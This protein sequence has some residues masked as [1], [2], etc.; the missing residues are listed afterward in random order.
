MAGEL[1]T[2][3]RASPRWHRTLRRASSPPIFWTARTCSCTGSRACSPAHTH[4]HM[5]TRW[6]TLCTGSVFISCTYRNLF[7]AVFTTAG[8]TGTSD[9]HT[10]TQ[11]ALSLSFTGC[12]KEKKPRDEIHREDFE[13]LI[14]FYAA[15]HNRL[16]PVS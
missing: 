13:L 3:V 15:P 14:Y 16:F 5:D 7:Y 10:F 11:F 8:V 1:A 4:T 6:L 2:G 12:Y 9:T